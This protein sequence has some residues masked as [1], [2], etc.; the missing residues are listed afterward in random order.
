MLFRNRRKISGI[1]V[2]QAALL[3]FSIPFLVSIVANLVIM[4]WI[5]SQIFKE[6][7]FE[8][9]SESEA[10]VAALGRVLETATTTQMWGIAAVSLL[11]FLLWVIYS[12][13]IFGPTVPILKQI[14]NLRSGK[15]DSQI[16]LRDRDE[17]KDIADAL[18][19]LTEALR[20]KK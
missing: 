16:K 8:M 19:K 2:D 15:Y 11:S 5:N 1:V 12:H 10:N 9:N 20:D 7:N 14:E 17:L 4:K 13:R 3:R 18:N 6:I